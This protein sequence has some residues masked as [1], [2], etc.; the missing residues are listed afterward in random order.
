MADITIHKIIKQRD[1]WSRLATTRV[2]CSMLASRN[3]PSGQESVYVKKN[4]REHRLGPSFSSALQIAS[5][6]SLAT[7]VMT[8]RSISRSRA[9]IASARITH[10]SSSSSLASFHGAIE[11]NVYS[12]SIITIRCSGSMH[13][14]PGLGSLFAWSNPGAVS[15]PLSSVMSCRRARTNS[16]Y[17]SASNVQCAPRRSCASCGFGIA[18]SSERL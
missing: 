3:W 6:L 8:C 15:T 14:A 9:L 13:T 18:S 4:V 16:T 1:Y 11:S 7:R 10:R 17:D 2:G 12:P 5:C